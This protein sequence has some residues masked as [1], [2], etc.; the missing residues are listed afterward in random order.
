[1]RARS[2]RSNQVAAEGFFNDYLGAT[3]VREPGSR[4]PK[5][6]ITWRAVCALPRSM[7]QTGHSGGAEWIR[8]IGTDF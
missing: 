7:P 8:T 5:R 4:Q 3:V 1:V 6:M 2:S